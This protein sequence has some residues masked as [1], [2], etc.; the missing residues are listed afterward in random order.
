MNSEMRRKL[1]S[2]SSSG[3][4]S[5]AVGFM[6]KI[7]EMFEKLLEPVDS[8]IPS[9]MTAGMIFSGTEFA[10]ASLLSADLW[11][12]SQYRENVD[13]TMQK[14]EWDELEK[15]VVAKLADDVKIGINDN[16]VEITIF[17]KI[18]ETV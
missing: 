16:E 2:A 17:K 13:E 6:G 3:K 10:D 8:E 18:K 5:S 15:S 9:A 11:S 7:K 4:N 1:L 14:E 12:L